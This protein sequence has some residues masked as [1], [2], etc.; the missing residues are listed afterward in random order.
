M[1]YDVIVI[2]GGGAGMSAAVSAAESS[3]RVLLVEAGPKLGGSTS[4]SGG[5]YY[6]AGTAAQRSQGID[7]SPDA[8]FRYYMTVNQYRVEPSLVRRLCDEAAAGLEWLEGFDVEF[9]AENIYQSGVDGIQ[10]GHRAV[11]QGAGIA[12]G[13]EGAVSQYGIDVALNTRVRELLR[14]DDGRVSG[15]RVEGQDIRANSVV[16][17]TGGFGANPR[18]LAKHY[19][20]A[21]AASDWAWYIGVDQCQGDGLELGQSVGGDV[22]GHNRGLLLITPGFARDTEPYMP[23]WLVYVNRDGRR[24]IDETTEYSVVSGVVKEQPASECFAIFDEAS[25]LASK[26]PA[27]TVKNPW[28]NP[29]WSSERLAQ[30]AKDKRIFSA[31]TLEELGEKA[32]I[33]PRALA[34]TVA[35]YNAGADSGRDSQFFKRAE[36]LQAIRKPPFYAARLRSAIVC[37]TATGLRIDTDARVLDCGDQPIAGLYAAGETTGGVMG[38][39]YI[40]GGNSIT[41]AIVFG[42][43]AGRS[44][45]LAGDSRAV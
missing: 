26:P 11:D 9:P 30:L 41:N 17:A 22:V 31:D 2:G 16:I 6:A 23:G 37:L 25:R 24:F 40:G 5:V 34:T 3:A 21:A 32:G 4:M 39:R 35:T 28:S 14:D 33:H 10:R 38:E 18:L 45:A 8:M 13:L 15:I 7:D 27:H 12:R 29:Q 1:D 20:E 43:I 42:R 36:L 44:A 19:P